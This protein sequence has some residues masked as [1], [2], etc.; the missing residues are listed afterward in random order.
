MNTFFNS[1][2]LNSQHILHLLVTF[3]NCQSVEQ[4]G[5]VC[6]SSQ[7]NKHFEGMDHFLI[8]MI[9]LLSPILIHFS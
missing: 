9:P 5:Y 6:I 2:F 3:H 1:L 8:H 4:K 7:S